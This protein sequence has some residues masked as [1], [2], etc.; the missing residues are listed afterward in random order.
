MEL[1]TLRRTPPRQP[2]KWPGWPAWLAIGRDF[3][4]FCVCFFSLCE[5]RRERTWVLAGEGQLGIPGAILPSSGS[6]L[7]I[8]ANPALPLPG[9]EGDKGVRSGPA[10]ARPRVAGWSGAWPATGLLQEAAESGV[11]RGPPGSGARRIGPSGPR[12]PPCLGGTRGSCS[13]GAR[14]GAGGGPV[15]I[16]PR[17]PSPSEQAQVGPGQAQRPGSLLATVRCGAARPGPGRP[18]LPSPAQP[19]PARPS[20]APPRA[21]ELSWPLAAFEAGP[22]TSFWPAQR[23]HV[24]PGRPLPRGP[25]ARDPARARRP[26]PGG[27]G[28]GQG[29]RSPSPEPRKPIGSCGAVTRGPQDPGRGLSPGLPDAPARRRGWQ[30]RGA[31]TRAA[32][33]PTGPFLATLPRR[34]WASLGP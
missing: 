8:P 32:H 25:G 6:A 7:R 11:G 28:P 16:W 4:C 26:S 23:R 2:P 22:V 1:R 20:P 31:D 15:G 19:S 18:P 33:L 13:E 34:P 29:G 12:W 21:P 30:R 5:G 27:K 14:A 24:E 3:L 9:E 10:G 17:A